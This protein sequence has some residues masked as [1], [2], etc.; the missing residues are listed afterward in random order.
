MSAN[1]LELIA[2]AAIWGASFLFMRI[3]VPDFGPVPMI[4]TRVGVAMLVLLPVVLGARARAE[5]RRHWRALAVVGVFNAALPFCMFGY[6]LRNL[7]ASYDAVLN[8]TAPLWGAVLGRFMF[9][10]PL[11]SAQAAGLL[12][13]FAGVVLLLVDQLTGAGA[14]PLPAVL[15]VL[16]ATLSYGFAANFSVRWLAGVEPVVVAWG[17][18]CAAT[19]LLL[20]LALAQWPTAAISTRA[21][22]T[23][24]ALGVACTGLAYVMYYR[25][26]R[27]AGAHYALSTTF[28]VPVF[29][30]LWGALLLGEKVSAKM[31]AGCFVILAGTALASGK[32]LPWRRGARAADARR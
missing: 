20:P 1:A 25:L 28:L 27:R 2:L 26:M 4:A 12:L 9:G 18:Q 15:A 32:I 3:A 10:R 7:N 21:W 22:L 16:V 31:A 5:I 11:G 19:L 30:I 24:A 13:G 6:S 17:T 14:A 29:G 23:V 8:A